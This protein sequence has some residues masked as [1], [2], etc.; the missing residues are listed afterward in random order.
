MLDPT[1]V[2]AVKGFEGFTAVAVWDFKQWTNGYG[3]RAHFPRERVSVAT[4]EERLDVELLAAQAAVDSLGV[5]MPDGVRKALTDLTFNAGFG[6]SHAGLGV[7]VK[8]C[9][10]VAAKQH[11]L[12]YDVAGGKIMSDLE[13]RRTTEAS[14]FPGE[15]NA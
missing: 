1:L 13:K 10:W 6:W 4:A 11:L 9:D 8:Q 3:T 7:A 5:S 15:S 14:W 12:E 2:E